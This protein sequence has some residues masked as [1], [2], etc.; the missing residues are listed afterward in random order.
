MI[1][2]PFVVGAALGSFLNVLIDR[3][4]TGRPFVTGRSYC[5]HCKKT[6]KIWDLLPIISFIMLRG[7]CRY[8]KAK[9]PLRIFVV[10]LL[11]GVLCAGIYYQILI[12]AISLISGIA[13][14]VLLFAFI[15]IIFA[16]FIYGII[17]D[18]LVGIS[19]FAGII[20]IL[21]Q[22]LPLANH[23]LAGVGTLIFFLALFL[24]TKGKGMGFG[25]VK[26][27]F[28]M[29]FLL[30]FPNIIV[31]LY[32]AF[33]TGAACSIILV[34]WRKVRF[35][36]GTIPFGPFLIV[37]TIIAVFYGEAILTYFLTRFL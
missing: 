36:G 19:F 2:L 14:F 22:N 3:L 37:S 1:L 23:I 29:G 33:L 26:F 4:S 25:D 10:E 21:N 15:G 8:C 5:E 34:V 6:L 11:I 18:L 35:F 7:R 16:D 32:L 27:S 28:V 12:N 30:G 13:L 17:P 24:G 20:F 31:G 9:I